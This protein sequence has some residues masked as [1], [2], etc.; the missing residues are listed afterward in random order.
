M[1]IT[2]LQMTQTAIKYMS[3]SLT[4]LNQANWT[5][6]DGKKF[7]SLSDDP[8]GMAASLSLQSSIRT[9]QAYI[10]TTYT[11]DEWMNVTEY[12]LKEAVDVAT[13]AKNQV[14]SGV[15]DTAGPE[16]RASYAE[17]LT[18][19]IDQLIESANTNLRGKFIFA[20]FAINTEPYSLVTGT[21]DTLAYAGDNGLINRNIS[22]GQTIQVNVDAE[23]EFTALFNAMVTAR[24]EL[25]ANNQAGIETALALFDPAMDDINTLRTQ[26]GNRSRQIENTRERLTATEEDM[27]T[28]LSNREDVNMAEAISELQFEENVYQQVLYVGSTIL[29]MPNLFQL[30]G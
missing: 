30:L 12:A 23:A 24:D 13:Q 5:A 11:T 15:S 18:G 14:L 3:D 8:A 1:R 10:D 6:A 29:N 7:H 16:E 26:N 25:L 17:E 22:P 9:N 28:L 19:L 21:P 27:K 2:H 4:R 20:G